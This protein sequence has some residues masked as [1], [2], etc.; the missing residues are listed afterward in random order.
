MEG[1][2]NLHSLLVRLFPFR[3]Q[4]GPQ[5][6]KHRVIILSCSVV[7]NSATLW[8]VACQGPLPWDFPGKK[9]EVCCHILL[10]GSSRPR[11]WTHIFLAYPALA[12]GFFT[13]ESP[14]K[15]ELPHHPAVP[16]LGIYP[17]EVWTHPYKNVYMNS[18]SSFI[19][20]REKMRTP[21]S[22]HWHVDK[23][24]NIRTIE[25]YSIKWIKYWHALQHW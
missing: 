7:S 6:V 10:Q 21:T 23:M 16:S 3:I 8:T 25:S 12:D 2:Q 19:Y 1:N 5:N 18:Q 11:D 14:G 20:N 13:S 4:S 15:T 22:N 9:T 24:G 17:R